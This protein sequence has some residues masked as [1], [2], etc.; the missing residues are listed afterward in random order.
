VEALGVSALASQCDLRD[1]TSIQKTVADAMAKY[2]RVDIL[3]KAWA[4]NMV[5]L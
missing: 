1:E 4:S 3:V 5:P 2:G